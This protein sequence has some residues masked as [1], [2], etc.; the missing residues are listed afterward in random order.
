MLVR[1][2][3]NVLE[4]DPGSHVL[5]VRAA[6]RVAFESKV[7]MEA[8]ERKEIVVELPIDPVAGKTTTDTATTAREPA[9]S[10]P[11]LAAILLGGAAVVS[12]AV[13]AGF[14][15]SGRSGENAVKN[16]CGGTTDCPSSLRARLQPD[17]DSAHSKILVGDVLLGVGAAAIVAGGLWW[18]L[19][20]KHDEGKRAIAAFPIAG[21]AAA[22]WVGNF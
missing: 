5:A 15:G 18:A 2:K 7:T 6:G 22:T 11:P 16:Q 21:G 19:S 3:A 9:S 17:I 12:I 20:P 8:S 10:G 13:G 14:V 4:V 1:P